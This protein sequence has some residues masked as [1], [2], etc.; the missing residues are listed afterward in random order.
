[1]VMKDE[2][3]DVQLNMKIKVF[4]SQTSLCKVLY[5]IRPIGTVLKTCQQ[6]LY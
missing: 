2:D 3:S 5:C 1:M 4:I 6:I